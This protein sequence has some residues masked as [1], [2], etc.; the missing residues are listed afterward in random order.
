MD[1]ARPALMR[2]P[3]DEHAADLSRRAVRL[4][5]GQARASLFAVARDMIIGESRPQ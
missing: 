5:S 3:N 1:D 4:T 2:A